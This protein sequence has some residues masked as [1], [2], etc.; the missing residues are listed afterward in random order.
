MLILL[1]QLVSP[2]DLPYAAQFIDQILIQISLHICLV[3]IIS[4][5]YFFHFYDFSAL[6]EQKI[7]QYHF[8]TRPCPPYRPIDN[9]TCNCIP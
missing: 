6:V 2:F 7:V 4:A 1:N 9:V 8:D 3:T 5:D